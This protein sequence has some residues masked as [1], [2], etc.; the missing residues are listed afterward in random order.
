MVK[1]LNNT[2]KDI[3]INNIS[4]FY[5]LSTCSQ[6]CGNEILINLSKRLGKVTYSDLRYTTFDKKE[7]QLYFRKEKFLIGI[8]LELFSNFQEV[9]IFNHGD[10]WINNR[11][12]APSLNQI[13]K[14][15]KIFDG[16]SCVLKLTEEI[17]IVAFVKSILRY[18]TFA[19]FFIPAKDIVVTPTDHLDIFI[20]SKDDYINIV[21]N[22]IENKNESK[23]FHLTQKIID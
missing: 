22:I 3:L 5:N 17:E 21:K 11:K 19:S 13:L 8:I 2:E 12:I 23:I 7:F 16:D 1:N 18:N 9:Y 20:F 6:L 14:D 10:K 4:S 15:N